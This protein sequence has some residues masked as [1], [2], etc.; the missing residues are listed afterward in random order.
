[1]GLVVPQLEIND[2]TTN[3]TNFKLLGNNKATVFKIYIKKI[4]LSEE[5]SAYNRCS[6]GGQ[7][8]SI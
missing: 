5:T 1:M 2:P 3:W 8:T 4:T 6:L 7:A